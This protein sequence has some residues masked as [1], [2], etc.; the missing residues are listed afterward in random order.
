[1]LAH[2]VHL[3]YVIT[4]HSDDLD[5]ILQRRNNSTILA[6]LIMLHVALTN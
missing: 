4:A 2:N 5:D 1:M 3:G 6:K